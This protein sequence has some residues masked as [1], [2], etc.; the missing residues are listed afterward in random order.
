MFGLMLCCIIITFGTKANGATVF[1]DDFSGGLVNW[2]PG[3]NTGIHGSHDVF[4]NVDDKVAFRQTYDYIET[5]SSYGGDN[6][7]ISF[8]VERSAGSNG[9]FDF[10][11]EIVEASEFSGLIRLRYGADDTYRINIGSAPSTTDPSL[12]GDDVDDDNGY[13]QTMTT[14]GSPY[15]GTVTYSY[16][17]GL[18]KFSFTHDTLGTIETPWVNTGTS[19]S[20]TRIRIWSNSTYASGTGTR[21]LDNV[22]IDAPVPG[23]GGV[24]V[25]PVGNLILGEGDGTPLH[26][27]GNISCTG[28]MTEG[29]SRLLKRDI[30]SLTTDEAKALLNEL[31]PVKYYYKADP[32][33][34]QHAGFIAEDVPALLATPDRKGLSAMDIV[35]ILTKVVQEQQE[36]INGLKRRLEKD[37]MH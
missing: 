36:E 35:A 7:Q 1:T 30:S 28:S 37:H 18:V 12:I 21:F 16:V 32:T 34:D 31:Q 22:T 17:Q 13:Q 25:D 9:Q 26:V 8:Q 6:F 3:T 11:V 15:I 27:L 19:F 23:S 14:S 24:L 10:L 20:D 29:S 33:F 2:T 4:I 5:N